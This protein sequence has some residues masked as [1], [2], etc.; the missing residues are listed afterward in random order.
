MALV[1][2]LRRCF[3]ASGLLLVIGGGAVAQSADPGASVAEAEAAYERLDYAAAERLA[4]AALA[5]FDTYAP[6]ELVRLHTL[7]GLLL[8]ARGDELDAATEFRAALTLDPSLTLDPLLVSP[9]TIGFFEETK[10]AFRQEQAAGTAPG[11]G[12]VV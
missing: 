9:A 3:F 10:V 7:L 8:Y 6:G 5:D 4:R 11:G 2:L 12:R 1:R